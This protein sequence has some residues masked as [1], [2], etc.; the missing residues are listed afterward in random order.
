MRKALHLF[1]A[2]FAV[3]T[4]FYLNRMEFV[5]TALI[6]SLLYCVI[7]FKKFLPE[8]ELSDMKNYG[9]FLYPLGLGL[10]GLALYSNLPIL[11]VGILILGI[12]DVAASIFDY[13]RHKHHKTILAGVVYFAFA[14]PVL[15]FAFNPVVAIIIAACLALT[16]RLSRGGSDDLTVPI[17]YILLAMS[18]ANYL[19]LPF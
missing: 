8:I 15:V 5:I 9:L 1:V 2:I 4:T 11:R 10:L 6:L 14:T 18:Y 17:V 19:H 12:P 3:M 13:I 16:E 7:Y